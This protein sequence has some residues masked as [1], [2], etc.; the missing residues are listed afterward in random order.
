M[1]L[2]SNHSQPFIYTYIYFNNKQKYGTSVRVSVSGSCYTWYI[3][4]CT[5]YNKKLILLQ[6]IL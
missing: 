2:S 6:F 1:L 4:F 5:G 3:D